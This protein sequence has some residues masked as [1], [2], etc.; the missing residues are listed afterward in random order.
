MDTCQQN[1][2][3]ADRQLAPD[4]VWVFASY[5]QCKCLAIHNIAAKPSSRRWR[6]WL[7]CANVSHMNAAL[8]GLTE[9]NT[10]HSSNVDCAK[11]HHKLKLSVNT[12]TKSNSECWGCTKSST[13]PQCGLLMPKGYPLQYCHKVGTKK[14][15]WCGYPMVKKFDMFSC[16]DII[17]VCD[18]QTDGQTSQESII[19]TMHMHRMVKTWFTGQKTQPFPEL[20]KPTILPMQLANHAQ[21][22]CE[23]CRSLTCACVVYQ[24]WSRPVV[25][26]RSYCQKSD[27]VDL[28]SHCN[29]TK[30]DLSCWIHLGQLKRMTHE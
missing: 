11:M 25:V 14:L 26:C 21:K 20:F 29:V 5:V 30:S 24:I 22:C 16:F 18:R 6:A 10:P 1:P 19:F 28:Q 4:V 12:N 3:P 7:G 8:H 2:A 15:E 23:C 13:V 27:F 17:L 9:L